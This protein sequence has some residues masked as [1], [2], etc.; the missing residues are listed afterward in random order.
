MGPA[1]CPQGGRTLAAARL[2]R[3]G[4]RLRTHLEN[5][6]PSPAFQSGFPEVA[7][8]PRPGGAVQGGRGGGRC[9]RKRGALAKKAPHGQ[10]REVSGDEDLSRN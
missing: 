4:L 10:I 9:A 7:C 3:C 8:Q 1:P 5:M 2:P 6:L